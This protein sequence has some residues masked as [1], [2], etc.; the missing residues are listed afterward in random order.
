MGPR[1]W[2]LKLESS[3]R[4]VPTWPGAG[5]RRVSAELQELPLRAPKVVRPMAMSRPDAVRALRNASRATCNLVASLP[6]IFPHIEPEPS[7]TTIKRGCTV[8]AGRA[9]SG[10]AASVSAAMA[11]GAAAAK[12]RA[13][14]AAAA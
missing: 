9:S 3:F 5:L 8:V 10:W 2:G 6:G 1:P 13:E 12:T 4:K 14:H 11:G 7:N